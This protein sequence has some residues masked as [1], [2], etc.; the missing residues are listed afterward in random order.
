MIASAILTALT[1]TCVLPAMAS[2]AGVWQ[3]WKSP[4]SPS[5][6]YSSD[7]Y[8][9]ADE[10]V[11]VYR[12]G[13]DRFYAHEFWLENGGGGYLGIQ[14]TDDGPLAMFSIWNATG[15]AQGSQGSYCLNFS[16]SDG[17]GWSCRAKYAWGIGIKYRLRV[18]KVDSR[19][20]GSVR[21]VGAVQDTYA[22]QETVLGYIWAPPKQGLITGSVSW[23]QDYG[24]RN[25]DNEEPAVAKFS[26]PHFNAGT[27]KAD[28]GESKTSTCGSHNSSITQVGDVA[29]LSE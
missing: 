29:I 6:Y 13:P 12:T 10:N 24:G 20:D 26:L 4:G 14:D 27:E 21:W 11:T 17:Q 18:W 16:Q 15:G 3:Y 28:F 25:C 19:D 8:Y 9:N 23:I 22:Q 2:Q 1:A 7:G 5:A